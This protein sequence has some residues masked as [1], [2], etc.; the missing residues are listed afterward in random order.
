MYSA[1]RSELPI[2]AAGTLESLKGNISGMQEGKKAG[3]EISWSTS[4]TRFLASCIPYLQP[5]RLSPALR[6]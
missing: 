2:T 5:G 4:Q 1:G 6:E 3:E